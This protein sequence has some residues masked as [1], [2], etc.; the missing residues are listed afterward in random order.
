[1]ESLNPLNYVHNNWL[2]LSPYEA[3]DPPESLAQIAGVP[4]SSIIKLNA[5]E[6]PFGPSPRALDAIKDLSN[7]HIYPDPA[8]IAMRKSI[9]RHLNISP[10]NIVVGNGSDEIIDLIFRSVLSVGD[11]IINAVP[12]FGMYPV[13]AQVCGAQTISVSRDATFRIPVDEIVGMAE[14]A[15]I[16]VIVSPNNPTGNLTSISD[17]EILLKTKTLVVLDEA[18]AEFSKQTAMDL[19]NTYPNLVIL[20]TLSKWGGLAGLRVGYG[21]MHP[22]LADILMRG[23]PPYS[24]SRAA[25]VALL[26]SL[27]DKEI[28]D[29]RA[30]A[31]IDERERLFLLLNGLSGITPSPSDANFILSHVSEGRAKMIYEGLAQNGI[32]VRYYSEGRLKDYLRISVGTSLQT[33][34]LIE[35]LASLL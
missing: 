33:D 2:Q 26:A 10:E 11:N 30:Q 1:M 28:L 7:V 22:L 35:V 20:R 4:E 18:Y 19:I 9:A 16:I 27:E 3:V 32:A 12:T 8:Q 21:V 24:V 14:Q 23:K 15:K 25:E 17:I 6:N 13:V 34:K 31:I 29:N 5:N